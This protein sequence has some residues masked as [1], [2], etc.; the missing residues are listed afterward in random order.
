MA[1]GSAMEDVMKM[2]EK[3]TEIVTEIDHNSMAED[4]CFSNQL[5]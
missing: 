3:E 1:V 4:T 5:S 2:S